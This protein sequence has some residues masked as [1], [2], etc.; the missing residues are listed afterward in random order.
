MS[1]QRG[2]LQAAVAPWKLIDSDSWK[3]AAARRVGLNQAPPRHL[4]QSEN[5]YC[6]VPIIR[7]SQTGFPHTLILKLL[8]VQLPWG[9][10]FITEISAVTQIGCHSQYFPCSAL[11]QD[12]LLNTR[13]GAWKRK[14]GLNGHVLVMAGCPFVQSC[15]AV[16][17]WHTSSLPRSCRHVHHHHCRGSSHF[18]GITL[19]F[20][21]K[22]SVC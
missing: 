19:L 4:F 12:P 3:P 22:F 2:Q 20:V 18:T 14:M 10:S 13:G 7:Q 21:F 6:Q 5:V 17:I 15:F 1:Q 16:A 8:T 9:C 11:I